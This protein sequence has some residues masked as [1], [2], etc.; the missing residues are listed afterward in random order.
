MLLKTEMHYRKGFT[1]IELLVVIAI[2]A[3]LAAMLL[4]ILE[5][6]KQSALKILCLNNMRMRIFAFHMYLEDYEYAPSSWY[7]DCAN[8]ANNRWLVED[9]NYNVH[10]LYITSIGRYLNYKRELLQCTNP[11]NDEFL[12]Y[13]HLYRHPDPNFW[14]GWGGAGIYYNYAAFSPT[15]MIGG[16]SLYFGRKKS[17]IE[18]RYHN[19]WLETD[20]KNNVV[21]HRGSYNIGFFDGHVKSSSAGV[22]NNGKNVKVIG[23][24]GWG[25]TWTDD[26]W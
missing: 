26:K 2:I 6:A 1:L 12:D 19:V 14:R 22:Y 11:M 24:G 18:R 25:S 3:I 16:N 9:I 8:P 4:P 21:R 15:S 17:L 7:S 20:A 13:T 23:S 5:N 10:I